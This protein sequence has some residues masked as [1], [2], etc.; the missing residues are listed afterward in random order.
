MTR[1]G[2]SS[3]RPPREGMPPRRFPWLR[4]LPG[5]LRHIGVGGTHMGTHVILLI[6]DLEVRIVNAVTGELLRAK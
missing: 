1:G 4:D 5:N 3:A 6:Q 2:R